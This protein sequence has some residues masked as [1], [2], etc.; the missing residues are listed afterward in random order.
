MNS[1]KKLMFIFIIL[2]IIFSAV[3]LYSTYSDSN[4]CLPGFECEEVQN[5]PYSAIF[6]LKLS[7]LGVIAFSA[8]LI[9][10]LLSLRYSKFKTLYIISAIIGALGSVYFLSIQAFILKNFC[11]SC[12]A[13]DF[14]MIIILIFALYDLKE[15]KHAPM[16]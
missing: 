15:E 10:L 1:I 2:E 11:S 14:L 9:V 7:T 12:V 13:I 6:G 4:I 5:S 3:L 16:V 8:L